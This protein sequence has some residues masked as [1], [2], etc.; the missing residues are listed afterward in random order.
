MKVVFDTDVIYAAVKS[1]KGAS[2]I[3][4]IAAFS[5]RI[6]PVVTT[7]LWLEY[8]AVLTRPK[9]LLDVGA[10]AADVGRIL[11]RLANVAEEAYPM[12]GL[13]PAAADPDDDL[14]VEAAV[15]GRVDLLLTFNAR[16]FAP[17][18]GLGFEVATPGVALAR[19][20]ARIEGT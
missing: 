19:Y 2:R 11:D 13:R 10:S 6:V 1:P 8:E 20:R 16:D 14:V 3:W 7:A 15:G 9:S 5:K 18:T 17:A 12:L 4:L